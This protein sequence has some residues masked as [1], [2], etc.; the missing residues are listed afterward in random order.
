[1]GFPWYEPRRGQAAKKF[2]GTWQGDGASQTTPQPDWQN[3]RVTGISEV[4]DRI[5]WYPHVG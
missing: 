1:M 2:L 5:G 4:K 3:S